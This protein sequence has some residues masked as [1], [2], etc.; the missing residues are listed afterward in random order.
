MALCGWYTKILGPV[1]REE[2]Q[3]FTTQPYLGS[4]SEGLDPTLQLNSMDKVEKLDYNYVRH[5][6]TCQLGRACW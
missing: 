2:G 3:L 6:P 1:L 4:Y 5:R